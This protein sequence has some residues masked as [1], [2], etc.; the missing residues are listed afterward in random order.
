VN[1]H[2]QEAGLARV[3]LVVGAAVVV[4]IALLVAV[5]LLFFTNDSPEELTIS[6]PSPTTTPTAGAAP[7]DASSLAGT[8]KVAPGSVAGYRVK[9]KLARLPAQSDAVG[10]TEAVTGSVVVAATAGGLTAEKVDV[11][12]DVTK[13]ASDESRRDN[14]IRTEGLESA[15]FPTATFV[16]TGPVALPADAA[17]GQVVKVDVPGKLTVHGVAKDVSIPVDVRLNGSQGEAVGSLTFPFSDFGMTPPSIGGFVTVGSDATL[18]FK[19]LL[20]RT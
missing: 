19:V 3:W 18:E 7:A 11:T 6:Q 2:E 17:G 4:P 20:A 9:E 10:R 16:S 15:Q 14:R 5:Y 8:W 12:V 1:T 13:L